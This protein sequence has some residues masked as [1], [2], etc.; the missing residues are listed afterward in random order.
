M[1]RLRKTSE[2]TGMRISRKQYIW[3]TPKN[4]NGIE[5]K[6]KP[7]NA[8]VFPIVGLLYGAET[9]TMRKAEMR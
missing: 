2:I 1:K 9:W 4:C 3:P 5:T 8:L 7:V 6:M